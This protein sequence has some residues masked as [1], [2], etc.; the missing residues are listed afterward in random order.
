M[1]FN[2]RALAIPK[3][4]PEYR[5]AP[6][7]SSSSSTGSFIFFSCSLTMSILAFISTS[8]IGLRILPSSGE[9]R[10]LFSTGHVVAVSGSATKSHSSVGVVVTP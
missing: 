10:S 9:P 2:G 3:H 4:G 5:R 7:A 6:N 1:R 8:S